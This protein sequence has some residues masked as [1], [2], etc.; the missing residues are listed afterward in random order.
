M[1][2]RRGWERIFATVMLYGAL[3]GAS[4]AL[5]APAPRPP[6]DKPPANKPAANK[7]PTGKPAEVP[8]ER[9][10]WPAWQIAVGK[11]DPKL[12][13]SI[14]PD[15]EAES[16]RPA[17]VVKAER[18]AAI[19][20]GAKPDDTLPE[21]KDEP[22]ALV[23]RVIRS[24]IANHAYPLVLTP[25]IK[26]DA[27]KP[28]VYRVTA[29]FAFEG[30][31]NVIATP[32]RLSVNIGA[33]SIAKSFYS[34]DLE[35]PGKFQTVSILYELD[36]TEHKQLA[37]RHAYHA[38]HNAEYF[39][40]VY[41]GP[42]PL[43]K[44][45]APLEGIRLAL[46]LPLTKYNPEAGLPPNSLRQVKIDWVKIERVDPAPAITARY[47]KPQKLWIRPGSEQPIE[48]SLQN[49]TAQPQKRIVSVYLVHG[50]DQ[51]TPI[52]EQEVALEAGAEQKVPFAWKTTLQT[53]PW[54]YEVVAEVKAP[55]S[56]AVESSARDFFT[57]SP[58]VYPALVM[59][60]NNRAVDPFRQN[61]S[62]QN[63]EEVFGA[64]RGDCAG[65][66]PP[67]ATWI[68][69]MGGGG[70][71][72]STKL[73]RACTDLNRA[74]GIATHMYL[75][76]GGTGA[77]VIDLYEKHPE[78]VGG[79]LPTLMDEVWRKNVEYDQWLAKQDLSK[80]LPEAGGKIPHAELGLIYWDPVLMNRVTDD[81]V[82]FIRMSGYDGIRFDVGL[83]GPST[84]R[85][86]L[87]T[88]LPYD[89]KN[90]MTVGAKN[91]E[92]F[93][94]AMRK[95]N[96]DFEF[97][98]NQDTWAYLEQVGVRN[99]TPKPPE[100]YPEWIAFCKAG[101][102]LM[103]EGTMDAPGYSHY[104]NRFEDALW[105]MRTKCATAR[106]YGGVYQL[107][108]P[109]RN[110]TGYFAH[111]DI[112]WST[113]IVTSGSVYVGKFSA[114][115]YSNSSMGAFITR[116]GEYFRSKGLQPLTD[117]ADKIAVNSPNPLWFAE[118]AVFEDIGGKRRY[119][120]PLINPPL[121]ERFRRNKTGEMPPPIKEAF[122]VRIKFPE[123][124]TSAK[125]WMLTWEP[126]V[127]SKTLVVKKD[128]D[129]A[130]IQFPGVDLCRTLVVEFEK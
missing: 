56:T 12:G 58:Q 9:M 114:P 89:M 96:P 86:V 118:T 68:S 72:Q 119:V 125:A 65:M 29:R 48:V 83:F 69:G 70:I 62:F 45:P 97:G 90:A 11:V 74:Q 111:D 14:E 80:G 115:P 128:G 117:A 52:G 100:E 55:A 78:W 129:A 57:V 37:A 102:M 26:W 61:E 25:L 46:D 6:A 108:S 66:T 107:F 105:G 36:P 24:E 75:F 59:G 23:Q 3:V 64:T 30:D 2:A 112:Y 34:I 50:I 85:T 110:G 49:Y 98:A 16:I 81:A 21:P 51:R 15:P 53:P 91:F 39:D 31:T 124:F 103:D 95:V 27:L 87:G 109:Y 43:T 28:G 123:G 77:P 101:G 76:A 35:E 99:V 32:V 93:A 44:P 33:V 47:V 122:E 8:V 92:G 60:S 120:V 7:P 67:A 4:Q 38:I 1:P 82:S 10:V 126:T 19:K 113:F 54:G 17:A 40:K 20:A 116:Y 63:L 130:S 71:P 5:A 79:R 41:P 22:V 121:T 127:G 106:K 84:I 88:T 73:T 42:R 18:A 13:L 94:A 104:M